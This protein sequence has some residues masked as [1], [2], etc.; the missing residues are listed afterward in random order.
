MKTHVA[1]VPATADRKQKVYC[2]LHQQT[3]NQS[4]VIGTLQEQ[5][6]TA[7]RFSVSF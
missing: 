5:D 6:T 3:P 2:Q 4:S 1:I 7:A